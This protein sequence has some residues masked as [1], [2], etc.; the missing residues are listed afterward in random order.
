[1]PGR[2]L[3]KTRYLNGLQCS[4]LLW[5]ICHEPEKVPGPDASAQRIFDQGRQVGELAKQLFPGGINI[6]TEDFMGNIR[7]T[8][9]ALTEGKP[10]F[11]AGFMTGRL[12]SRLDI[13]VPAKQSEW[14]EAK[15]DIYEVKSSTSVREENLQ[16]MAFQRYCLN[17]LGLPAGRCRLVFINNQYVRRGN[18]DPF[19]L[20]TVQDITEEVEG[21]SAGIETRIQ[22][23][24]EVMA[25]QQCPQVSVGEQC[26]MPYDCAVTV[27][28][29][30]L[31]ENDIFSL[32][33][34]GRKCFDL[35]R[36]GIYHIKNIP[37][38]YKLSRAQQIQQ[39]CLITGAPHIETG[40]LHDFLTSLRPPLHYLDFE[41]INPALPLFDGV[42]PYQRIPFQFSLHIESGGNQV[43]HRSFLA[44]G[45]G[46]P[47]PAFLRSLTESLA[48]EGSI[49]TYNQPFE[50]GVLKEL[51]EAFPEYREQ[52]EKIRER[53]VDLLKPFQ[54]FSYYHPAQE[55]SA[56][57]KHV[58]PAL[59][60][61][62]YTDMAIGDGDA[63]SRAFLYIT[64]G[65]ATEEERRQIR[66]DLEQYC[67]LDTGGMIWIVEKLKEI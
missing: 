2:L 51:A 65:D 33:R 20:F 62:G 53:L 49:V 12:F 38:S 47:R 61:R 54:E 67:G 60:G 44:E 36:Q 15:W 19:Q 46:D 64:Y 30:E 29:D 28:C 66:T 40:P 32:Y 4:K 34:G 1:M 39:Q 57:I 18:I 41:T 55:G 52:V 23:M 43:Q 14:D 9:Q 6:P 3:S 63:A 24:L 31:P 50:E 21:A 59:T 7:L 10:L 26:R 5:L 48:P 37:A 11:E 13:L 58:L 27:C 22:S 25:A 42:R 17:K 16:D 56:S 8:R 45:S 35:F